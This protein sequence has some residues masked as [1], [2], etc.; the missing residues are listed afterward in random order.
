M[1][2]FPFTAVVGQEKLKLALLLNA[3]DPTIG[4]V[5]IRGDKGSAK[6]TLAR[7]LAAVL[8]NSS[9]FVEVP[10]GSTEDRVK[11]SVDL[12]RMVADGSV[13]STGGLLA[14]ANGGV[15]YIDEVNLLADHIVDLLLDA[16]A[17]GVN[18]IERDGVSAVYQARFVLV[19]SMN[20]EEGELR[21]QLLDRFGL[22]VASETVSDVGGRVS[23]MRRRLA[24]DADP[25]AFCAAYSMQQD[26]LSS[27][28]RQAREAC[29]G[30]GFGLAAEVSEKMFSVISELCIR[31]GALGL[32]ADLTMVRSAAAHA[33]L[34]GMTEV[35]ADDVAAVAP[36]V[37][38]HRARRDPLQDLG[39]S[40][41]DL[42]GLL[43]EIQSGL[44]DGLEGSESPD[45]LESSSG[46]E[47]GPTLVFGSGEAGILRSLGNGWDR[48]VHSERIGG[49]SRGP[50]PSGYKQPLGREVDS[51]SASLNVVATLSAA[52][53]RRAA[54]AGN[55]PGT[56]FVEAGDISLSKTIEK[57]GR[58][59]FVVLDL[60]GS[61]SAPKR[62]H[63]A[64][65]VVESLLLESYQARD[66]VGLIVISSGSARVLQ[67]PTRSV[68]MIRSKLA[69]IKSEGT[70]PLSVGIDLLFEQSMQ[71]ARRGE[72]VFTVL[73]T[74]GRATGSATALDDALASARHLGKEGFG[75]C[76]VDI[77]DSPVPMGLSS[78]IAEEMGAQLLG[79]GELLRLLDESRLR[80]ELFG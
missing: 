34:H 36:L 30:N 71:C 9:P 79:S 3:V 42:D 47:S 29:G 38:A 73:I 13:E 28:L 12:A 52:A 21:P 60:S 65:R 72:D 23:A 1:N 76:V 8:P 43:G 46:T 53:I 80:E 35:T 49:G 74:D 20:P 16:A 19:G 39:D 67:R 75:S 18:R 32:R 22:S 77:E 44:S 64:S 54:P 45:A 51:H 56:P 70:T 61:I 78:R 11:G 69:T 55:T 31:Y 62:I 5:L 4:G 68:E 2:A 58:T 15:L 57:G 37:L 25:D 40:P 50:A 26:A 41:R 10:A 59:V 66:R 14:Q 33:C 27:S 17:S 24:Y 48:T 7:S 63:L 6:S